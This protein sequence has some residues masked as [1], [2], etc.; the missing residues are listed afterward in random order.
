MMG[1]GDQEKSGPFSTMVASAAAR[2][3]F[4]NNLKAWFDQYGYDG[5]ALDWEYPQTDADKANL[6]L[7]LAE[8]RAAFDGYNPRKEI[9]LCCHGSLWYATWVDFKAI[10]PSVDRF[11]YM[12]YDFCGD[13]AYTLHAGHNAPLYDQPDTLAGRYGNVNRFL[14]NLTDS[15]RLPKSKIV[16]GL[17]FYGRVFYNDSLW[18][19]PREGGGGEAYN[20]IYTDYIQTGQYERIWD[21]KCAV[22][23]L[24]KKSGAQ[25][26]SYDDEESI[27]RK[28]DYIIEQGLSG[29]FIWEITQ[30]YFKDTDNAP[31][32]EVAGEKLIRNDQ[33]SARQPQ[34]VALRPARIEGTVPVVTVDLR[35]RLVRRTVSGDLPASTVFIDAIQSTNKVRSSVQLRGR[36]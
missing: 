26:V 1:G 15:L 7:L 6:T 14:H 21:E 16:M 30:D 18:D 31:L 9:G 25:I 5:V 28:C 8:M 11:Y 17:A 35:G 33:L 32:L 12:A 22:P 3:Q 23:Y 13:W 29:G 20:K 36:R 27:G 4:V 19:S 24:K 10:E 2:T 34:V